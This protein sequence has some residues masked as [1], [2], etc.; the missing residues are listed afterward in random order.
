MVW[1]Q[2]SHIS[3]MAGSF[4]LEI[5]KYVF[6]RNTNLH[7]MNQPNLRGW[8]TWSVSFHVEWPFLDFTQKWTVYFQNQIGNIWLIPA[9]T[10]CEKWT[11]YLFWCIFKVH[12]QNQPNSKQCVKGSCIVRYWSTVDA[13]FYVLSSRF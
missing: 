5:G 11:T 2:V 12:L 3:T 7:A 10:S 4:H 1:D 9:D 8:M 13:V 6:H